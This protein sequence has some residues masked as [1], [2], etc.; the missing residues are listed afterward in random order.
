L[1]LDG[2]SQCKNYPFKLNS[3]WLYE[4]DFTQIVNEVW[5]DPK[6]LQEPGLQRR[7][8]WKMKSLKTAIK[9][10][11]IRNKTQTTLK[12]GQLESDLQ[13]LYQSS[14]TDLNNQELSGQIKELESERFKILISQ[15][16]I[17]G[18]KE[19]GRSG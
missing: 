10:W 15:K 1:Q 13:K 12:L 14:L 3:W 11:V 4:A 2:S 8:V 19:V 16:R 17:Y 5:K 7:L 6:F 18:D 9:T